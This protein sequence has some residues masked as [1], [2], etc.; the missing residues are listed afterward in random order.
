MEWALLPLRKYSVTSGRSRRKEYWFFTL[1]MIAVSI[2]ADVI[3]T[4]LGLKYIFSGYF[5]PVGF[6]A[7]LAFVIPS[8]TV[9]IRRL[10]DIDRTGWWI[11]LSFVPFIG[12]LVLLYLFVLDGTRGPNRYGEDPKQ[13]RAAAA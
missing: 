12:W 11:L 13:G 10:H 8:F 7:A 9:G 4:V 5:G 3:D 6:L 2:I 1:L